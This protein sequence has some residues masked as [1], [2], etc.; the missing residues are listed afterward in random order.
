LKSLTTD[1]HTDITNPP[2]AELK[3]VR[4]SFQAKADSR[5]GFLGR[6]K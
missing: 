5:V 4:K 1:R 6:E 2:A 3:T